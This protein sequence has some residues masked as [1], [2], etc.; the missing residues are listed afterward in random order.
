M[1]GHNLTEEIDLNRN[2]CSIWIHAANHQ[3]DK[4]VVFVV[5]SAAVAADL[6]TSSFHKTVIFL[7]LCGTEYLD[8]KDK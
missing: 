1:I 4:G 7:Y 8:F 3:A 6:Q 5:A 2:E